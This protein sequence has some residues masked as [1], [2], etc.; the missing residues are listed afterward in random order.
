MTSFRSAVGLS[1]VHV[2]QKID[3]PC[4]FE[5]DILNFEISIFA[6]NAGVSD[7]EF[8]QDSEYMVFFCDT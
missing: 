4:V 1:Q 7:S 2:S 8:S 6:F 3:L 5:F